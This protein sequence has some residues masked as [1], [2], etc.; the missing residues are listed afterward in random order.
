[1]TG[2][3]QMRAYTVFVLLICILFVYGLFKKIETTVGRWK[4]V[5]MCFVL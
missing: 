1:M 4:R 5:I 2:K 3:L